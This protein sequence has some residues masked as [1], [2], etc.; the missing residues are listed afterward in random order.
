VGRT[1]EEKNSFPG[2]EKPQIS[3]LRYLGFPVEAGG[4]DE[5]HADLDGAAWQEIRVRS[6]LD[7]NS[8]PGL[9]FAFVFIAGSYLASLRSG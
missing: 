8:F 3:P 5:M 7:D 1:L 2:V 4:V 9:A 6:G